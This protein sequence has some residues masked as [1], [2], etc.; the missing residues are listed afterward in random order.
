MWPKVQTFDAGPA[1]KS[2]IENVIIPIETFL[3]DILVICKG[4]TGLKVQKMT[5][6]LLLYEWS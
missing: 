1:L 5:I 4:L 2:K 3:H 6:I